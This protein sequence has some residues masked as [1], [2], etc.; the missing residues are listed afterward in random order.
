[1]ATDDPV[2]IRKWFTERPDDNLGLLTGNGLIAL[3]L[4][5]A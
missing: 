5:Q 3:D 2:T 4:N 1:M